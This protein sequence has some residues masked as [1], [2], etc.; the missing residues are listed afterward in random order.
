MEKAQWLTEQTIHACQ[1]WL[2][3]FDP[4]KTSPLVWLLKVALFTRRTRQDAI[5]SRE[6]DLEPEESFSLQALAK[7]SWF[8]TWLKQQPKQA[9]EVFVLAGFVGMNLTDTAAVL[10][11]DVAKANE[12]LKTGLRGGRV[13]TAAVEENPGMPFMA[14]IEELSALFPPDSDWL[15]KV[16]KQL[17]S[18]QARPLPP[19]R[20]VL[21]G[22]TSLF[23]ISWKRF[24]SWGFPVIVLL[25]LVWITSGWW[26]NNQMSTPTQTLL[27]IR[28]VPSHTPIQQAKNTPTQSPESTP[29]PGIVFPASTDVLYWAGQDGA[30]YRYLLSDG[31]TKRLTDPGVYDPQSEDGS[32]T[33]L[34]PQPEVSPDGRFL[35]LYPPKSGTLLVDLQTGEVIH[36]PQTGPLAWKLDGSQVAF[37]MPGNPGKIFTL[38]RPFVGQAVLLVDLPNE[39]SGLTS[40]VSGRQPIGSIRYSYE[41]SDNTYPKTLQHL[42]LRFFGTTKYLRHTFRK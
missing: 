24:I 15:E 27:A 10:G 30:I 38:E 14:A 8:S 1:Q 11:M 35:A 5:P 16:R 23:K 28:P 22:P 34:P 2:S 21:D 39:K 25:A 7:L 9:A 37:T 19:W 41:T 40:L 20:M 18:I 4:E 31:T 17:L 32:Q 42:L 3:S 6:Y 33:T 29:T 36:L 13:R 12:L 26:T